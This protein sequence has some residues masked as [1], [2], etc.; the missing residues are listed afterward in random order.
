MLMK[1]N[2][3]LRMVNDQNQ[4]FHLLFGVGRN[5]LLSSA[6]KLEKNFVFV[7]TAIVNIHIAKAP[8]SPKIDAIL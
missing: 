7:N 2:A 3:Q 5:C 6:F 4:I 8:A 1:A